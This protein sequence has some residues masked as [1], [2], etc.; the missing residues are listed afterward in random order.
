VL[1]A[2]VQGGGLT[3]EE[4]DGIVGAVGAM[5]GRPIRIA[6]MIPPSW[7]PYIMGRAAVE[8]AGYFGSRE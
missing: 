1:E 5:A 8:A 3:A 4:R 2:F 6:D 7:Q